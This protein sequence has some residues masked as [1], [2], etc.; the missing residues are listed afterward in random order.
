M[1]TQTPLNIV[2]L[3]TRSLLGGT[4][5]IGSDPAESM[6][7]SVESGQFDMILN[8][9]LGSGK[10]TAK[11]GLLDKANILGTDSSDNQNVKAVFPNLIESLLVNQEGITGEALEVNSGETEE[12]EGLIDPAINSDGAKETENGLAEKAVFDFDLSRFAGLNRA[13]TQSNL[14]TAS[15]DKNFIPNLDSLPEGNY[16]VVDAEIVDGSL[17]LALV[18]EDSVD[19]EVVK[20]NLPLEMLSEL[21]SKNNVNRVELLSNKSLLEKQ[22]EIFEKVNI[23]EISVKTVSETDNAKAV[24]VTLT[25]DQN[26]LIKQSKL[27]QQSA[28]GVVESEDNSKA[29]TKKNSLFEAVDAENVDA[30]DQPIE[31]TYLKNDRFGNVQDGQINKDKL[32]KS[33]LI[34]P[35][36][37]SSSNGSETTNSPKNTT[38]MNWSVSQTSTTDYSIQHT[39]IESSPVKFTLPENIQQNLIPNS[40]AVLIKIHPENLGPAKL[41]LIVNDD[42]LRARLVVNSPVAKEAI[43]G[44]LDRL[45]DQLSKVNI[46]VDMIDVS[47]AGDSSEDGLFNQQMAQHQR[48]SMKSINLRDEV[49]SEEIIAESRVNIPTSGYVSQSGVNLYA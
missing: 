39:K 45:V 32:I 22:T 43:E 48:S 15:V 44:S 8:S 28:I 7:E 31:K 6:G 37:K 34:E 19:G 1:F 11:D 49:L 46:K 42:K 20:I 30:D 35:T 26:G 9:M 14:E 47:I 5:V 27:V 33:G 2:E 40:K 41:S 24:E 21:K 23:Q 3:L 29:T 36:F 38:D 25:A 17:R 18:A 12:L 10:V 13:I 16:R 4:N